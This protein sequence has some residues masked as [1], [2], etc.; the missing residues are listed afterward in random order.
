MRPATADDQEAIAVMVR[1]RMAWMRNRGVPDWPR[2]D[3]DVNTVAAQAAD[4]NF[5]VRV[6]VD[7]RQVIG[8]TTVF[9]TTPE[10]GWTPEE[11]THS[12]YFLATSFTHPARRQDRPGRLMAWWALDRA[13]H[14]GVEWVRRGTFV[15]RL[16]T[17]Y[18]DVQGWKLIHTPRRKSRTV[19]LMARRAEALPELK[20]LIA[21]SVTPTE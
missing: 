21:D 9:T 14:E 17:Y 18:R 10:W 5:P 20:T 4:P 15:E 12:A 8:C 6:L 7:G 19:Y 11:L 2:N 16:M 13:A 1:A 3:D